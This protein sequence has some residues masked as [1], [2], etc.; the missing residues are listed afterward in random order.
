MIT[1]AVQKP[2]PGT[3]GTSLSFLA[4]SDEPI[5]AEIAQEEQEKLGYLTA[6]YGFYGFR[7]VKSPDGPYH[8]YWTCSNSC[9]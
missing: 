9:E 1:T 4:I 8:A 2:L 7:V 3:V 6:G 5:T